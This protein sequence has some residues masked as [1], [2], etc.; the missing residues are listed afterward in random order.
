MRTALQALALVFVLFSIAPASAAP[1]HWTCPESYSH[2][3]YC[4]CGCGNYD[5]D[6]DDASKPFWDNCA[7][8][9]DCRNDADPE[10][11]YTCGA[12]PNG[13]PAGW[14]CAGTWYD[15]DN[16]CDCGCGEVDPDCSDASAVFYCANGSG[17]SCSADAQCQTVAAATAVTVPPQVVNILHVGGM[18]STHFNETSSSK[19]N[20]T[21]YKVRLAGVGV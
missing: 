18:C 14:T 11:D 10:G 21:V 12:K 19:L 3:N 8:S 20:N 6:C 4:D 16:Y 7:G 13:V 1:P 2:D 17:T 5:P 9:Y 15:A